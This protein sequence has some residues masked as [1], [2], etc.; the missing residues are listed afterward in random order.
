[1]SMG[2]WDGTGQ[3]DIGTIGR[4]KLS[5]GQTTYYGAY[6]NGTSY[7]GQGTSKATIP[8]SLW[9]CPLLTHG[10][11]HSPTKKASSSH[12]TVLWSVG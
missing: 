11:F 1:M 5:M 4:P 8:Q 2:L 3:W 7:M 6:G 9:T 10:T 12:P